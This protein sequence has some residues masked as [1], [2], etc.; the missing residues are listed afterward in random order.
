[1]APLAERAVVWLSKL[2]GRWVF[3]PDR[4]MLDV[5]RDYERLSVVPRDKLR[6]RYPRIRF[7]DHDLGGIP[8]ESTCSVEAPGSVLLHLHG[9]V[10]FFGSAA[11]F[12]ARC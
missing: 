11:S 4:P 10:Y 1:M 12:R 9:G 8:T 3:R 7:D 5:R 6:A 2:L